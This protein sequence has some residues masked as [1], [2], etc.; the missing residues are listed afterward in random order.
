MIGAALLTSQLVIG[1]VRASAQTAQDLLDFPAVNLDILTADGTQNI[2]KGRYQM[3][4]LPDG[5]I[6]RG[7][8][9]YQ[10]GQY[11]LETARL[12]ILSSNRLP[13]LTNYEH[14]YFDKRGT[15]QLIVRADFRSG[16]ALCMTSRGGHQTTEIADLNFPEDTYSGG[17]VLIPIQD[18]LRTGTASVLK[19]HGFAC[20]PGPK[21]ITVKIQLDTRPSPL[22]VFN[23][24]AIKIDAYPDFGFWNF[25]I[26]P[27]LPK[28][29]AWF[30]PGDNWAFVGA[31]LGRYYRGPNIV[32]VKAQPETGTSAK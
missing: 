19:L 30:D 29:H 4:R 10:D 25:F 6:L 21:I 20:A 12:V 17:S 23:P 14:T 7:E 8:N 22:R 32:M 9:H 18:F 24:N 3:D 1:P 13:V 2:G 26:E 16:K 28:L 11:D 5:G 27:L 31:E 15:P